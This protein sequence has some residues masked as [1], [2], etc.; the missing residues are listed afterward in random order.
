MKE[1]HI[2]KINKFPQFKNH[3]ILVF[4]HLLDNNLIAEN[5][6]IMR[7]IGAQTAEFR[8]VIVESKS[9]DR[10]GNVCRW[11]R[12]EVRFYF[13]YYDC[14][15]L[16][17]LLFEMMKTRA[18]YITS[19]EDNLSHLSFLEMQRPKVKISCIFF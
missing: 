6:F 14:L 17:I 1:Y 16:T 15:P 9:E 13:S 5:R 18:V 3:S 4:N 8:N 19:N 2:E 10:M 11:N 7:E 12:F